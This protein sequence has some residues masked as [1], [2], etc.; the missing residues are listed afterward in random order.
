MP[1]P[2]PLTTFTID[3]NTTLAPGEYNY[4]NL[5]IT[6]NAALTLEGDPQSS[7]SFKGVK[8]TAVSLT[9]TEGASISADQK[10][11]VG[12]R[13]WGCGSIVWC[14]KPWRKLWRT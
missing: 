4:D 13:S 3:K 7:N 1:P 14:I 12:P 2:P 8:I 9:I 11:M 5:V 10:D 6:N